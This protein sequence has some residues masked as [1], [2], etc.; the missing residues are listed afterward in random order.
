MISRKRDCYLY[1]SFTIRFRENKLCS[2]SPIFSY[3]LRKFYN[4]L[5]S[6]AKSAGELRYKLLRVA[7]WRVGLRADVLRVI[8]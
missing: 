6:S 5:N 8:C 2:L 1:F 3:W 7:Q 4:D